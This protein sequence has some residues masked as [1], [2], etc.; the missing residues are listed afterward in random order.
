MLLNLKEI[1]E[2][3]EVFYIMSNSISY[4]THSVTLRLNDEQFN[5]LL[6]IADFMGCKPS[7]Y[8]QML[9]NINMRSSESDFNN[10]DLQ[11]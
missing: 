5:Y 9:I 8:I 2:E 7:D 11:N 1:L 3:C 4:H 6:M 10:C